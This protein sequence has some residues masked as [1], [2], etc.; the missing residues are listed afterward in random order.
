MAPARKTPV[1]RSRPLGTGSPAAPGAPGARAAPRAGACAVV[2]ALVALALS[3]VALALAGGPVIPAAAIPIAAAAA[4]AILLACRTMAF[5]CR[6]VGRND[7]PHGDDAW[8]SPHAD[9]TS[10]ALGRWLMRGLLDK[11]VLISGGNSGIGLASAERFIEE[12]ARVFVAGLKRGEV[13]A[14]VAMLAQRGRAGGL[15]CDVSSSKDV[16]KLVEAAE[17]ALGGIDLL[18]NNTCP[19]PPDPF[20]HL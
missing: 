13:D 17:E 4:A 18:I 20:P 1:T 10:A 19:A 6:P 16:A 7:R 8:F 3:P 2:P 9:G 15:A 11:G 12:G 5:S 14:A